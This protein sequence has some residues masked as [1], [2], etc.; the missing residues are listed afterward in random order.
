MV[1]VLL[2]IWHFRIEPHHLAVH[3]VHG[4][5][6][7]A[8]D[9]PDSIAIASHVYGPQC[10]LDKGVRMVGDVQCHTQSVHTVRANIFWLLF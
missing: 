6:D 10:C 8:D 5:R 1:P 4:T 2:G 7:L 9:S 3:P